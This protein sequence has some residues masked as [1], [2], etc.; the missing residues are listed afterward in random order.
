MNKKVKEDKKVNGV[1][2]END[3]K[4]EKVNKIKQSDAGQCNACRVTA[5]IIYLYTDAKYGFQTEECKI[6]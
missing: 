2:N 3:K 4:N 5:S 1:M 6:I